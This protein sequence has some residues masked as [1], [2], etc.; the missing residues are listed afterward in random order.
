MEHLDTFAGGQTSLRLCRVGSEVLAD[1]AT[2]AAETV[3]GQTVFVKRYI[4]Y[5]IEEGTWVEQHLKLT[6]DITV[7]FATIGV[8]IPEDD[9]VV[10]LLGS[11]SRSSSTP[12]KS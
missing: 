11:L 6:K 10:T 2:P 8:P 12:V 1:D 4:R 3:S 7:E 9:Q 5:D